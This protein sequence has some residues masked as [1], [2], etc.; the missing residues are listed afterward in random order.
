M[1][2]LII[3]YVVAA[4]R[5]R[6]ACP[7]CFLGMPGHVVLQLDETRP[8]R[9]F[10][11]VR[12]TSA[13]RFSMTLMPDEVPPSTPTAGGRWDEGLP[14]SIGHSGPGVADLQNRL[15]RLGY[16]IAEA[17]SG[18]YGSA[19]ASAV[20]RF[21]RDRGLRVDG[22]CG[23]HTWSS[24]VEAGFR[25]GDRLL[26]RRVPMLHGDD[27]AELQSRLSAL[28]FDPGRV[29][30]IFGD[31]TATALAD[32]QHNIGIAGDGICGPR[33]LAQ[34]SRLAL[35]KGGDD[36]VSAVRERL[37]VHSTAG[38]LRDRVVVVGEPGGFHTGAAALARALAGVGA[39]PLMVT[40]HDESDQAHAAN[41]ASADCF[42]GLRLDSERKGVRTI[43]Y[44]GYRYE[45][46]P[47]KHL[48]QLVS[49]RVTRTL[50]LL[51]EGTEGMALPVLRQT[52]MP[53]VVVELGEP[54]VVA[55]H[56]A[57]LAAAITEALLEWVGKDWT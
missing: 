1:F 8:G 22:V 28:G 46:E 39:Q 44:R 31:Q 21:Q 17:E 18:R 6:R 51:D 40:H 55:M 16:D 14:F 29:D 38:S 2:P 53:A 35:R 30:G 49:E 32:F 12:N 48:A 11:Y 25:L 37:R 42:V 19:T 7:D 3:D 34:L 23:R 45:S 9:G 57:Q 13:D 20:R 33:T 15:A 24:V 4:P 26:Y 27:V 52:R 54:A 47:S 43:Y 41:V 5:E 10:P 56:T 50:E 36:L